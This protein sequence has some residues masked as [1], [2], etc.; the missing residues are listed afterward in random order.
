MNMD[1]KNT[2]K[3]IHTI[4]IFFTVIFVLICL[5][6]FGSI[7]K[8]I[9][10]SFHSINSTE[11]GSCKSSVKENNSKNNSNSY[12]IGERAGRAFG[13]STIS[14]I[15]TINISSKNTPRYIIEINRLISV[16][17]IMLFMFE[18]MLIFK[19]LDNLQYQNKWFSISIHKSLVRIVYY[20][21]TIFLVKFVIE[22]YY[23]FIN[24]NILI[25]EFTFPILDYISL[26]IKISIAF[27]IAAVYK[28]G[29]QLY[30]D[31]ELTI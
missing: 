28:I 2:N 3:L 5:M 8:I 9:S 4:S 21:C 11:I 29:L 23:Y 30:E 6:G 1:L 7:A 26:F 14:S 13:K 24:N 22:G 18:C 12:I 16:I 20:M 31:Q 17:F 15:N 19:R 10:G 27:S 25:D